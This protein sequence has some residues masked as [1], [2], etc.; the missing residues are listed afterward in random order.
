[1]FVLRY[2]A[3]TVLVWLITRLVGRL[4]PLLGRLLR[5]VRI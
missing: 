5:L 2:L 3:R 1:M 4:L